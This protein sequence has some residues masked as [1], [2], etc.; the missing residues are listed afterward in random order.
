MFRARLEAGTSYPVHETAAAAAR[1]ST[2]VM[3]ASAE[4]RTFRSQGLL[5][6][7]ALGENVL[8]A[9]GPAWV[10]HSSP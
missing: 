5:R 2:L 3:Q 7:P 4:G 6:Q 10:A 1:G 8:D 9:S